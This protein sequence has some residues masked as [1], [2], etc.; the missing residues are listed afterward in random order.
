MFR[1]KENVKFQVCSSNIKNSAQQWS[2]C[3]LS[4]KWTNFRSP[5]NSPVCCL[6]TG[7]LVISSVSTE[8][9]Q[10]KSQ[11]HGSFSGVH[12]VLV[13]GPRTTT[14]LYTSSWKVTEGLSGRPTASKE[15]ISLS[16]PLLLILTAQPD[17]LPSSWPSVATTPKSISHHNH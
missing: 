13:L 15:A 7:E 10:H 8:I 2:P 11:A 16:C 6:L 9:G 12:T 5:H 1:S 14:R 3:T 17:L 4:F